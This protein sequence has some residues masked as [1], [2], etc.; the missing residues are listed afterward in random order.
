MSISWPILGWD[1]PRLVEAWLFGRRVRLARAAIPAL[2]WAEL[3]ARRTRYGRWLAE[4]DQA[5]VPIWTYA[6][7]PIRGSS[8]PVSP[9]NHSEHVH[10]HTID[11]DPPRNPMREDGVLVCDFARF[12]VRDGTRF[13]AAF[14]PAFRWGGTW[15]TSRLEARRALRRVGERIRDGRVDPMHLELVLT[16]EQVRETRWLRRLRAYR[17]AHP[18]YMARVLRSAGVRGCRELLEAWREGRA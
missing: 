3:R 5:E 8:G 14:L 1:D 9:D 17:A 12:G 15:S 6:Y 18:L 11:L 2:K 16:Q 10:G 7:R 13:L 4:R